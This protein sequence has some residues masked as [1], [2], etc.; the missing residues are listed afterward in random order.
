MNHVNTIL[1]VDFVDKSCWRLKILVADEKEGQIVAG[2]IVNR[3]AIAF[4][5]Q[6]AKRYFETNTS[7]II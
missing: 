6:K 3:Y 7:G 4:T 2:G 1:M 5:A